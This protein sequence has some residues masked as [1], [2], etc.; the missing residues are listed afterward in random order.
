MSSRCLKGGDGMNPWLGIV[1]FIL[2][3]MLEERYRK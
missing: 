1:L 2:K 3:T